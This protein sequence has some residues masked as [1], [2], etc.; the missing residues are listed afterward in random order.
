MP[1]VE[2]K[3]PFIPCILPRGNLL[4]VQFVVQAK[5]KEEEKRKEAKPAPAQKPK[6][7]PTNLLS[8]FEQAII[9]NADKKEDAQ[10]EENSVKQSPIYEPPKLQPTYRPQRQ[11]NEEE[12]SI[13]SVKVQNGSMEIKHSVHGEGKHG[14]I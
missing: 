11:R 7:Q 1:P 12:G 3:E 10:E 5:P 14:C 6:K 13:Q 4:N 2:S 8:M 9:N